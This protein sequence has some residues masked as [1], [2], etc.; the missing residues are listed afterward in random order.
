MKALVKL[1]AAMC[2]WQGWDHNRII[3][4]REH[5]SRKYD[6]SYTGPLRDYVK[7]AIANQRWQVPKSAAQSG[8]TPP[9]TPPKRSAV[10]KQGST[11]EEVKELQQALSKLGYRVEVTGDFDKSTYYGVVR[12]Q[13]KHRLTVD[14]QI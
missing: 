2:A 13:R 1:C 7:K 3:H 8:T 10:L 6:M 5:T 9:V 4:H 12:F 14:G 11:G